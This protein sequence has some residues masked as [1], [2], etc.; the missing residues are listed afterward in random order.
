M[1]QDEQQPELEL[2]TRVVVKSSAQSTLRNANAPKADSH[3]RV[4]RSV[5]VESLSLGNGVVVTGRLEIESPLE[6]SSNFLSSLLDGSGAEVTLKFVPGT[7]GKVWTGQAFYSGIF[8]EDGLTG[9]DSVI[10]KPN[11]AYIGN[12]VA[13]LGNGKGRIHSKESIYSGLF[14]ASQPNGRGVQVSG[15]YALRGNFEN[16]K[17]IGR[18]QVTNIDDDTSYT[19]V[20]GPDG[21]KLSK[22]N[23]KR[24][25]NAIQDYDD[26]FEDLDQSV[27]E[28]EKLINNANAKLEAHRAKEAPNVEA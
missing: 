24:K 28:L 21:E 16:G 3:G 25:A 13:G 6:D 19:T 10:V 5:E 22:R 17:P 26:N 4:N 14:A 8:R 11:A 18:I 9:R 15:S 23:N 12:T 27:E 1:S 7:K 2:E 20:Y